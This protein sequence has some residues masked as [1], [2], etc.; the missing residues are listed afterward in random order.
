[1]KKNREKEARHTTIPQSYLY[2]SVVAVASVFFGTYTAITFPHSYMDMEGNSLWLL[3]WDYWDTQLTMPP[4]ASQW[5]S[6]FLCQFYAAPVLAASIQTLLYVCV[7]LMAYA[8]LRRIR[9]GG[10]WLTWL[11]LLP[12]LT[13]GLFCTFDACVPVQSIFLFLLLLFYCA[14]PVRRVRL[15]MA[16]VSLPVAY[17]L[18]SMPMIYAMLA[19]MMLS[20]W[21]V[22]GMRSWWRLLF[23]FPV[24]YVIPMVYS[25]Q[26]AFVPFEK[27]YWTF[28]SY[29]KP[30]TSRVMRDSERFRSYDHLAERGE[31]N[32]L[33]GR[34]GVRRAAQSG[35]GVALR[36]AL[37]AESA[38][39][40]LPDNLQ[41][42]PIASESQFLFQHR[43]EYLTTLFN[44]LFY[45]NLGIYDEAYHQI[46]E[47]G[48]LQQN[49]TC[50]HSL[51]K[52]AEYSIAEG[53]WQVAE[54]YLDILGKSASH[55]LYVQQQRDAMSK[56]IVERSTKPQVPLRSNT[57]VGGYELPVEM[58]HLAKYYTD[59]GQRKKM[60]DYVLCC[61]YLRNDRRRFGIALSLFGIY[62]ANST[63]PNLYGQFLQSPPGQQ[64][65]GG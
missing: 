56:A 62:N 17:M 52:M 43:R 8:W 26:V 57:F 15:A 4:A 34:A 60:L 33:L 32:E 14:L 27:R 35:D 20:E 31:W 44:C 42:Y 30:L 10:K 16:F 64:G 29:F 28:G 41:N 63:L 19:G 53:E 50:F 51:R 46:Q 6:S 5:L 3:T 11:G 25:A 23:A 48:L 1:M 65:V 12:S 7:S 40:T 49:G 36:Y 59:P 38:L 24:L 9:I 13:M 37:L 47:F 58:L 21:A 2:I 54:K 18:M 61:Y 39:G 45:R 22:Y 55:S